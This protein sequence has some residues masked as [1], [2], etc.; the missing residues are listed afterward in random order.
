M[1]GDTVVGT[2]RLT[3]SSRRTMIYGFV[4]DAQRR[5]QRRGTRMLATVM[6]RLAARGV[7]EVGLEPG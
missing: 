1:E 7:G 3:E 2:L 6:E 4:I 5:G